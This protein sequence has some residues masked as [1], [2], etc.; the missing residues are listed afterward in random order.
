ME[1]SVI[2]VNY[3]TQQLTSNCIESIFLHTKGVTF[4]IILVDNASKDGSVEFFSKDERIHFIP[5]PENLGFGRANNLGYQH[6]KGKY[7][8]AL[9]SDTILENDALTLFY[10][11]MEK[12]PQ[13]VGCVGTMLLDGDGKIS[14]SYLSLPTWWE[15]LQCFTYPHF[16]PQTG[17][18]VLDE[19]KPF[20]VSGVTGADMFI[21]RSVIEECGFFDTDFFM[22]YE[23]TELQLRFQ[24][25]G[26]ECY[27]IHGPRIIHL[28][29]GSQK[30][31]PTIRN[32]M[33]SLNGV[34]LYHKKA[35][36]TFVFN[37]FRFSLF[38]ASLPILLKRRYTFKERLDYLKAILT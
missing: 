2:I 30:K 9:N 21:R 16:L 17:F 20:Q 19:Q 31:T 5:S 38:I 25:F 22:Y 4:E 37:I 33:L 8:F 12:L 23:E 32:R 27:I 29:R 7:I 24:K 13:K 10:H 1:V 36:N 6:S 34:L 15:S 14:R 28:E 11:Q 26:Y 18:S 35:E 3:N